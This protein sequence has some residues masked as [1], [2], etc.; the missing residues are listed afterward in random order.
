MTPMPAYPKHNRGFTLMETIVYI[1][2][3]GI[4]FTGIFV[5]TYPLFTSAERLTQNI[6]IEGESA[7]IL[8]KIR[9]VLSHAV[10]SS[11]V[12]VTSPSPNTSADTLV[13]EDAGGEL[14]HFALDTSLAFCTPLYTCT[15]LTLSEDE[16][17]ALPLNAQRVRIEN[18]TVYHGAPS[19][20]APRYLDVSFEAND[21]LI[22]PVRYYLHF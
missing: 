11:A 10:T 2:L 12:T 21:V 6:A 8:S 18:F 4:M 7:F 3:F 1:G 16:G 17:D 22:G 15:M 13:I 14:F 9:Y 19:G 20:G 5:S